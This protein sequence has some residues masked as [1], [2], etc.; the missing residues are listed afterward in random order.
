MSS[1]QPYRSTMPLARKQLAFNVLAEND[2]KDETF[3]TKPTLVGDE[4]SYTINGETY[5][6]SLDEY[7]TIG[8]ND[9]T[10]DLRKALEALK[11]KD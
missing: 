9:T 4:V 5:S 10:F 3:D 8:F 1:P 11:W 7:L 6:E 2:A